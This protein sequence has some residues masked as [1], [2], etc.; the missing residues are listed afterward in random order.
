MMSAMTT[1]NFF[2][3]SAVTASLFAVPLIA[4]PLLVI[5][6]SHGQS[7][8]TAARN[9]HI[10]DLSTNTVLFSKA[11]NIPM[12][13]AS[14]S[15]LMT[16]YMVFD[17]LKKGTLSLDDKL[18]VSEKA[19]KKGGSKMFV[20]VGDRISV[21]DLLRGIIVQS[22]NDACIVVA[23]A[24]GGSEEAFA[25]MMTQRGKEI[26]LTESTFAN[27]TGWPDPNHQMSARDLA[28]LSTRLITDF[29]N[30]YPI[31]S[32]K[33]FTYSKIK[34]GNRNPLLYQNS[35][36]DGLKTGH[37]EEAGYGLTASATR[38]E[39]RVVMVLNGMQSIRQRSRESSRLLEWAFRTFDAYAFFK[40][41]DAVANADVWLGTEK[42]VPLLIK[43]DLDLTL[44]RQTRTAMKVKVRLTEP[45]P[46]PIREGAELATL[47]ISAPDFKTVEIPLVAGAGVD[48]LGF[49][50]RIGAAIK[51]VV[52]GSSS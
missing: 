41:G 1:G 49:V 50:G 16:V 35:G 11:D 21:S 5:G 43:Q 4:I 27:A 29:P 40:T 37:T 36:A 20:R 42:T 45:V 24:L 19:W 51:Y 13:P 3:R 52:W 48:K 28:T 39:R 14:M 6:P 46:A 32:E 47:V 15:K 38:G 26:G 31:F 2:K 9:A 17:R 33:T 44:R 7:I 10:V 12:P 25:K 22:G 30:L 34:Q 23:E 18:L 8:E